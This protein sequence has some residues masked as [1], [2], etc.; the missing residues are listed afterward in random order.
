M[1]QIINLTDKIEKHLP[2]KMVDFLKRVGKLAICRGE[3]AYL[4][5]GIVRDLLLD[6]TNIDIDL[7]IEGNATEFTKA[8]INDKDCKTTIH[9]QFNTAKI[10]WYGYRVDL[11]ST[12]LES[13]SR[14]GALPTI[15]LGSIKDDLFR[16]DFTIN[17]MAVSL[18]PQGYGSLIDPYNGQKD[19]ESRL[20]RVLHSKSFI[21][22]STRIWRG[23]RYEQRLDFQL[24]AGT[25]SF[26]KR[27]L[28]MLD[29][30]SGE[31]IR[32]ELECIL[33]ED[34]PEKV[35]KR[36]WELGVLKK[37]NP[38]LK[39]GDWLAKKYNDARQMASPQKPSLDIY[40]ALLTYH[41]TN[42][43]RNH[44]ISYL[45][46]P[47][48]VAQTMLD[49]NSIR[50]KLKE[51]ADN[52]LQPSSIY[53]SLNCY[54]PHAIQVGIIVSESEESRDNM[55]LYLD[56]LRFIKPLLNGRDLLGMGVPQGPRIKEM[57]NKLLNAKLNGMMKTRRD[58]EAIVKQ[59]MKN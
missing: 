48:L 23:L 47:K 29:C 51:L 53:H 2:I 42:K 16:R 9:K 22:D 37:L 1:P 31:R 19:L 12:R 20:I 33:E 39:A 10:T 35:F 55:R 13:Y 8:L 56:K 46:L 58:E 57:L 44:F 45:R 3:Q 38:S 26:L 36:A 43:E 25:V 59:W 5:G 18:N 32:Y 6:K 7:A 49:S 52:T 11:I 28:S 30:I 27:D 40:M 34:L 50:T 21:D 15:Q 17:A 24:E 41:L 4:V 14:P 54:S